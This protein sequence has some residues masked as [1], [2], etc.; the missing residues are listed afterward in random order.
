M[1]AKFELEERTDTRGAPAFFIT[2]DGIDMTSWQTRKDAAAALAWYCALPNSSFLKTDNMPNS[3]NGILVSL[4]GRIRPT[5]VAPASQGG[6]VE[7]SL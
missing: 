2:R 3:L 7:H 1:T 6:V 4:L 5:P